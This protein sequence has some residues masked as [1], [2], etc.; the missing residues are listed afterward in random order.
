[1]SLY[2]NRFEEFAEVVNHKLEPGHLIII[3]IVFG[4]N[5]MWRIRM[6][7]SDGPQD[8]TIRA[9]LSCKPT[10]KSIDTQDQ[11]FDNWHPQRMVL[12]DYIYYTGDGN[13][14]IKKSPGINEYQYKVN[15]PDV[16]FLNI[17]NL[18]NNQNSFICHFTKE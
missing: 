12:N 15:K 9:W 6:L 10:G 2:F 11:V 8:F 4:H 16:Y 7:H 13:K 3:P 1:M 5:D 18:D 14:H 17:L